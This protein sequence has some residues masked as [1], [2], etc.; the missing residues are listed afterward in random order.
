MGILDNMNAS[1][2]E[3]LLGTA[4]LGLKKQFGRQEFE[5]GYKEAVKQIDQLPEDKVLS[6]VKIKGK[7][8][9]ILSD[10]E[11]ITFK[12]KPIFVNLQEIVEDNL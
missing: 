5:N 3:D 10:K 1:I 4:I 6:I 8:T 11:N 2:A 7:I 9:L 12:K